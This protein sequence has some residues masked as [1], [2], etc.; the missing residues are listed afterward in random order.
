MVALYGVIIVNF[1]ES[2]SPI[3]C[4]FCSVECGRATSCRLMI[5]PSSPVATAFGLP[6]LSG[7]NIKFQP[8]CVPRLSLLYLRHLSINDLNTLRGQ[9][10]IIGGE[11]PPGETKRNRDGARV[12]KEQTNASSSAAIIFLYL[13]RS[14]KRIARLYSDC[15][16]RPAT[17]SMPATCLGRKYSVR[18][19]SQRLAVASPTRTCGPSPR[20]RCERRSNQSYATAAF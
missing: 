14:S 7:N 2:Q 19:S 9:R 15:A 12:V 20:K 5:R 13:L 8:R 11:S 10:I 3:S 4:I 16:F 1:E 6:F 18:R 17:S